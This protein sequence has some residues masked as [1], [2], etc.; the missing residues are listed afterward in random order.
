MKL[1]QL[2]NKGTMVKIMNAIKKEFSFE[3]ILNRY[4][5]DDDEEY[6]EFE[7]DTIVDN[8]TIYAKGYVKWDF[9]TRT[10]STMTDFG[11]YTCDDSSLENCEIEF[12]EIIIYS[13]DIEIKIV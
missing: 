8:F 4:R 9:I 5:L 11:C 6:F 1:E 13:D 3:G 7:T 10:K 12:N 2:P